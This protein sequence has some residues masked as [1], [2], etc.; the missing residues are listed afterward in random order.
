MP[1][2]IEQETKSP[3]TTPPPVCFFYVTLTCRPVLLVQCLPHPF[4]FHYLRVICDCAKTLQL[5]PRCTPGIPLQKLHLLKASS[6][7]FCHLTTYPSATWHF[8][9]GTERRAGASDRTWPSEAGS[10]SMLHAMFPV[11]S[12]NLMCLKAGAEKT[13]REM[14]C[15][16]TP[17]QF[18]YWEA[19]CV[20]LGVKKSL[21]PAQE[22]S[23]ASRQQ[24]AWQ[25]SAVISCG[26]NKNPN[27]KCPFPSQKTVLPWPRRAVP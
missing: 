8:V 26:E 25:P 5:W 23:V 10:C 21:C 18:V 19:G 9:T 27:P 7:R 13:T 11:D 14:L 4:L 15:I 2:S 20:P 22:I 16:Q 17:W 24:E 6:S 1:N 3:A 12:E